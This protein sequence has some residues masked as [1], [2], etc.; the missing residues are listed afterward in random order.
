LG[1][2]AYRPGT[3]ADYCRL[4]ID[5]STSED[6]NL[7]LLR[8]IPLYENRWDVRKLS[9]VR[10]EQI[11]ETRFYCLTC[12]FVTYW[13]ISGLEAYWELDMHYRL[14][15]CEPIPTERDGEEETES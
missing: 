13:H 6:L 9:S 3:W 11:T 15:G 7:L 1:L 10:G 4:L 8:D 2:T 12:P 14:S 5:T